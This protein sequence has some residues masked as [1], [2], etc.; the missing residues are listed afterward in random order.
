E[1]QIENI[2]TG[3]Y[4]I[5]AY[6]IGTDSQSNQ[7]KFSVSTIVIIT[8]D[9]A[10][11]ANITYKTTVFTDYLEEKFFKTAATNKVPD[12]VAVQ[13]L[14]VVAETFDELVA[15]GKISIPS[16]V[17]Q[18][19]GTD[20][21]STGSK[22]SD[23]IESIGENADVQKST[24]EMEMKAYVEDQANLTLE[25][26]KKFVREVMGI[27]MTGGSGGGSKDSGGTGSNAGYIPDFF[28]TKFAESY[29]EGTTVTV[30][31]LV[32]AYH[33]TVMDQGMKD[34]TYSVNNLTTKI[35]N[36]ING[37]LTQYYADSTNPDIP[38]AMKVL[39]PTSGDDKWTIPIDSSRQMNVCQV[40][41]IMGA[42]DL[43]G[44]NDQNG[45]P[46]D[47]IVFLDQMGFADVSSDGIYVIGGRV[48]PTRTWYHDETT[49]QGTEVDA[50]M[51][52]A[53]VYVNDLTKIKKVVLNYTD[54]SGASKTATLVRET[55]FYGPP[56]DDE[57]AAT[58]KARLRAQKLNAYNLKIAE[59]PS[60][61]PFKQYKLTPW[62]DWGQDQADVTIISDFAAGAATIQVIGQSD[63]VL[64]TMETQIFKLKLSAISWEFPLGPDMEKVNLYGWDNSF[65]PQII[66][67]EEGQS[68]IELEV[69]W[70]TPTVVEGTIPD[71]HK[72]AYSLNLGLS[73]RPV[74]WGNNGQAETTP[75]FPTNIQWDNQNGDH[76]WKFIWSSWD[77]GNFIYSTSKWLPGALS[78]TGYDLDKNYVIFYEINI[79]PILIET[80]SKEV[81]W[82]GWN[83][84]T[85]FR[86]GDVETVDIALH[87]AVDFSGASNLR[88]PTDGSGQT[89]A[90]TWKIGLFKMH[91]PDGTTNQHKDYF[92]NRN[93]SGA[94]LPITNT[95]GNA[96]VAD[97]ASA[98]GTV[99]YTLPTF[100]QAD[101]DNNSGYSI[102]LWYDVA[103]PVPFDN[104][105]FG[106]D[107]AT[108]G[109]IDFNDY[110]IENH[111]MVEGNFSYRDG[112]VFFEAWHHWNPDEENNTGPEWKIITTGN[113]ED[114]EFNLDLSRFFW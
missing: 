94:R 43:M 38:L 47:P 71:G 76:R 107:E 37:Y 1:Y 82:E 9:G 15:D 96:V 95:S 97:L 87:G 113:E 41:V 54:T 34:G 104:Q 44:G 112:N 61:P 20:S 93:I 83:T 108:A 5:V 17:E 68:S 50:L 85:E 59:D 39:F 3:T 89:V 103:E 64:A 79:T 49:N 40:L 60:E 70:K 53:E 75:E 10:Q 57:N 28:I 48:I 7:Y 58:A 66:G 56:P 45:P 63:Q 4:K 91:G 11:L 109:G 52:F 90:G 65:E 36:T 6:K 30:A 88:L 92:H 13:L 51:I 111:F 84:R 86:I 18:Y 33:N 46:F 77:G 21:T 25:K 72:L 81:V 26:A 110:P 69:K 101:L 19:T 12:E 14:L 74:V 16:C 99:E 27:Q 8:E 80:A 55:H 78:K 42:C 98:S 73:A 29:L 62:P 32:E 31:E 102:I 23:I 105:W 22:F 114:Q 100:T 24:Q 106:V 2:A 35:V 67:L